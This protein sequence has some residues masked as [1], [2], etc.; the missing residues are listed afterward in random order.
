MLWEPFVIPSICC[1]RFPAQKVA[2]NINSDLASRCTRSRD[3]RSCQE[4][5]QNLRLLMV[6]LVIIFDDSGASSET[7][8][9]PN[10][11]NSHIQMM[12]HPRYH[13]L[14]SQ[15]THRLGRR[16]VSRL[17]PPLRRTPRWP[18]CKTRVKTRVECSNMPKTP[19]WRGVFPRDPKN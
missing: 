16:K 6:R 19:T 2:P 15:A 5:L 14:S 10:I 13:H 8:I 1:S 3:V 18:I 12:I 17:P 7:P 4:A 11:N 9:S